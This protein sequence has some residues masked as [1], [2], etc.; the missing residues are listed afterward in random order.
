NTHPRIKLIWDRDTPR[1]ASHHQ[2]LVAIDDAIAFVGGIDLTAA[3]RDDHTHHPGDPRRR[4][5]GLLQSVANPYHDIQMAVEGEIAR[6]VG[7]WCRE[8]WR[9]ATGEVVSAPPQLDMAQC[10]LWPPE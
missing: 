7:E 9:R 8:R 4:V 1:M 2:K 10:R 5:P 3:R 6:V